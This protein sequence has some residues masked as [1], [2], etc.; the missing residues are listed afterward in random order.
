MRKMLFSVEEV[1]ERVQGLS[2][3]TGEYLHLRHFGEAGLMALVQCIY[4]KRTLEEE[5]AESWHT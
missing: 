3:L 4:A 1:G 5:E 2:R